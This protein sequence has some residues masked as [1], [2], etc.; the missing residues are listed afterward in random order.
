MAGIKVFGHPASTATRRVLI[1]L[2]EK[3]LD[4]EFVHI[5]L[6]DGEHKQE[7]YIFRNPFGKVPAFED[8]D[9]KLFESRA[10]TQYIAHNYAD[11][12]NN[13]LSTG[14]D[15]AIIAMGIEIESHEFD[16]VGSKL[17]WEQV[18]KPL[19]GMTTDKAVVEEEEAKLAK[20]LDVYEHRLGD[21]KY[22]AADHFTLVDLHIIPVI[23]YLLGTPTKK[24]F[25][26]RTHVSAWVADITSRPSAQ[27]VL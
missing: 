23:Q 8:G 17:V 20:V 5:E 27:K 26:E 10:I 15:M 7:P 22:L 18:L 12:G 16:P 9:F 24:L 11:K 25:D 1:A 6:K 4:F 13:L 19:Y 14:K 21:S 2:H 3:N